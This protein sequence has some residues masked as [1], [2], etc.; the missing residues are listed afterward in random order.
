MTLALSLLLPVAF[1]AQSFGV[2]V[3]VGMAGRWCNTPDAVPLLSTVFSMIAS[4]TKIVC[5]M[6]SVRVTPCIPR[7]LWLD[8][9]GVDVGSV[10]RIE[11][12]ILQTVVRFLSIDVMD[13]LASRKRTPQVSLH[14]EPMLHSIPP[15]LPADEYLDVAAAHHVA[16]FPAWMRRTFCVWH[17]ALL[18]RSMLPVYHISHTYGHRMQA[19]MEAIG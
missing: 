19:I 18:K 12:K 16:A 14:N 2:H 5:K 17:R 6:L 1:R 15:R 9:L 11:A 8:V 7:R 13:D 4:L 10:R 3:P